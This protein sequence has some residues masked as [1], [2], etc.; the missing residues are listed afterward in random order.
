MREQEE[1]HDGRRG[2]ELSG[3]EWSCGGGEHELPLASVDSLW[4][5]TMELQRLVMHKRERG[6][7]GGRGK[8]GEEKD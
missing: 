7:D 8:G 6:R 2:W 5:A 3:G 1:R 4:R